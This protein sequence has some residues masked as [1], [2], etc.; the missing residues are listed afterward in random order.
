MASGALA[1]TPIV[2]PPNHLGEAARPRDAG[3]SPD[4]SVT[5]DAAVTRDAGARRDA[6]VERDAGTGRD[7]AASDTDASA[8]P[9]PS[10]DF[11]DLGDDTAATPAPGVRAIVPGELYV[12]Y[13]VLLDGGRRFETSNTFVLRGVD[14]GGAPVAWI[15]GTGYGDGL[16]LAQYSNR[17]TQASERSG[18]QDAADVHRIL[19]C[20]GDPSVLQLRV[21]APHG[22]ADHLNEEF[23]SALMGHGYAW[24][25]LTVLIHTRDLQA[26]TCTQC[27]HPAEPPFS[28]AVLARIQPMGTETSACDDPLLELAS[29][30]LGRWIVTSDDPD[31]HT[32]G[33][34]NLDN[35]LL[36]IRIAGAKLQDHCTRATG[37]GAAL[38][39]DPDYAYSRSGLLRLMVHEGL[40][41]ADF[42]R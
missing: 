3:A 39:A 24:S 23:I 28:S 5:R 41:A 29:P 16:Y 37:T 1:C 18:A 30:T 9:P 33:V 19:A 17:A 27:P 21:L 40:R 25:N 32:A 42:G 34:I 11:L 31:G 6:G 10:C 22:H 12:L 8:P 15:H 7:A 20:W 13:S 26:A 2:E 4:A 35:A 36:G 14:E 38:R